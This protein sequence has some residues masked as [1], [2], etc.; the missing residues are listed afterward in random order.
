MSN[1]QIFMLAIGAAGAY[2]VYHRFLSPAAQSGNMVSQYSDPKYRSQPA[3]Q[4]P[5][6]PDQPVRNDNQSEPWYG[7]LRNFL[8]NPSGN[9]QQPSQLQ[10]YARDLSAV[11]S[12]SES[13]SDI[14][15]NLDM[16]NWFGSGGENFQPVN[17]QASEN[18]SSADWFGG[19]QAEESFW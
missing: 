12:I 3:M 16:G 5:V 1:K 18:F 15:S 7:G 14:W 11:G 4:Y 8:N 19:A 2:F 13:I 17:I 10:M 6:R 9:V